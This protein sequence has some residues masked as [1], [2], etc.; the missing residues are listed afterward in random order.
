MRSKRQL[1]AAGG[2]GLALVE[3][4]RVVAPCL[5]GTQWRPFL[6]GYRDV[7]QRT[8]R[9]RHDEVDE[10]DPLVA[11][12]GDFRVRSRRGCDMTTLLP[13]LADLPARGVF[14]GEL[15]AFADGVPHFPLVCEGS[16]DATSPLAP[17]TTL[18]MRVSRE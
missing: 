8:S 16:S 15:V 2:N 6:G 3:V 17:S 18:G 14:D 1:V 7:P 11:R 5:W 13:E 12:N 4:A 9:R 10:R